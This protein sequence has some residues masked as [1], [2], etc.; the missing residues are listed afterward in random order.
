V[1]QY[2]VHP[3]CHLVLP[4]A[5]LVKGRIVESGADLGLLPSPCTLIPDEVHTDTNAPHPRS[6]LVLSSGRLYPPRLCSRPVIHLVLLHLFLLHAA[7]LQLSLV[8]GMYNDLGKCPGGACFRE[9]A[10]VDD[11]GGIDNLLFSFIPWL[12]LVSVQRHIATDALQPSTTRRASVA[13][14]PMTR[15]YLGKMLQPTRQ[16]QHIRRLLHPQLV[17]VRHVQVELCGAMLWRWEDGVE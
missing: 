1:P 3:S 17:K 5:S 13:R 12:A 10:G 6:P 16:H 11:E 9:V 2:V 4:V 15:T 7:L 8:F 14:D